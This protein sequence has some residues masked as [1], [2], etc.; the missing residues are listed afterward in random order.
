MSNPFTLDL[1]Q[2][3]SDW[4]RSPTEKTKPIR[5]QRLKEQMSTLPAYFQECDRLCYRQECHQKDRTF[6]VVIQGS[7]PE[8]IASWT[9][10]LDVAKSFKGGVAFGSD[11][12]SIILSIVP[13]SGTVAANLERLYAEREFQQALDT[14][15]SQVEYFHNGAGKYR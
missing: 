8:T 1:V 12:R 7:L 4:Q 5:G 10:C 9:T 15:S 11:D 13:P 6:Q 3:V 2:A 14:Y